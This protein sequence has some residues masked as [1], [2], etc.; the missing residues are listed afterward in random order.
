MGNQE[1]SPADPV[2]SVT[3]GVE[4]LAVG[5]TEAPPTPKLGNLF[6]LHEEEKSS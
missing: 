1:M 6:L 5:D 2:A 3:D 4:K